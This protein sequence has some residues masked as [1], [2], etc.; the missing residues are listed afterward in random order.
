MI[1]KIL[2]VMALL[3]AACS[4]QSRPTVGVING[5]HPC[6]LGEP[7]LGLHIR[8]HSYSVTKLMEGQ[9]PDYQEV[10]V[11]FSSLGEREGLLYGIASLSWDKIEGHEAD[12]IDTNEDGVYDAIRYCSPPYDKQE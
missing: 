10:S 8:T 12:V 3:L 9:D 4:C 1:K 5:V 6:P 11:F 2:C 7:R